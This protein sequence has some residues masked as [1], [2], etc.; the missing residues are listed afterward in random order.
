MCN[1]LMPSIKKEAIGYKLVLRHKK[2]GKYF[3][4]AMGFI[5]PK[6]KDIPEIKKQKMIGT[7]WSEFIFEDF[8][9]EG[10]KGRTSCFKSYKDVL[11]ELAYDLIA[12]RWFNIPTRYEFVL[13]RVKISKDILD[14]TYS[15]RR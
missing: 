9:Q 5:Y 1:N 8:F 12:G 4:S 11:D 14:G 13:A 2:T 10:M 15:W 3:S 6:N 7:F